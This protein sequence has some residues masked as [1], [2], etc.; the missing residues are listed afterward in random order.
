MKAQLK[1]D[2]TMRRE[3]MMQGFSS[4][5]VSMLE[6]LINHAAT[7][8]LAVVERIADTAPYAGLRISVI[9]NALQALGAAAPIILKACKAH[10]A[11]RTID[12]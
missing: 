5:D 12:L 11:V 9:Y 7:E 6:D 1:L 4:T 2:D 8:A 10:P 3:L